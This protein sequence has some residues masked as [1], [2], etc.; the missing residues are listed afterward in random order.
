M[1]LRGRAACEFS[2]GGRSV[3]SHCTPP[4]LISPPFI[5]RFL[6]LIY[7]LKAAKYSYSA[8]YTPLKSVHGKQRSPHPLLLPPYSS[9][10]LISALHSS[11]NGLLDYRYS[12]GIPMD[13]HQCPQSSNPLVKSVS[14]ISD[15]ICA[16]Y[17][18]SHPFHGRSFRTLL[19][20]L[21]LEN[22]HRMRLFAEL[23]GE[24]T[25]GKYLISVRQDRAIGVPPCI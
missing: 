4:W 7:R 20:R 5:S 14:L 3:L 2:Q 23:S 15:T 10:L 18:I 21:V 1:H 25:H 13:A 9:L 6:W 19:Q 22:A 16:V 12:Q 24:F 17:I 8:M 11:E